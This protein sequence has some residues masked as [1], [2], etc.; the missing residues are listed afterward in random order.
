MPFRW[1]L[2]VFPPRVLSTRIPLLRSWLRPRTTCFIH[3]LSRDGNPQRLSAMR[4]T[5]PVPV[6]SSPRATGST[7]T[8]VGELRTAAPACEVEQPGFESAHLGI[9]DELR[10]SRR[11]ANGRFLHDLLSLIGRQ[12]GLAREKKLAFFKAMAPIAGNRR[13]SEEILERLAPRPT[14]RLR[15]P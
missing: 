11:H 3:D 2:M 12:A 9:I 15:N 5:V 10:Q 1:G 13:V 7:L 4:S 6:P 14:Y 8:A